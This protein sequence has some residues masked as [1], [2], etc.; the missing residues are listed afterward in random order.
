VISWAGGGRGRRP[1]EEFVMAQLRVVDATWSD[2]M[3]EYDSSF[4]ARE[5]YVIVGQE[6]SGDERGD[7]RYR[8][9]RLVVEDHEVVVTPVDWTS[10][11]RE[12]DSDYTA[13]TGQVLVGRAHDGGAAGEIRYR[14]ATVTVDD[15]PVTHGRRDRSNWQLESASSFTGADDQVLVGRA[16]RGDEHGDTCCT[17]AFLEFSD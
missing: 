7:T 3:R 1:G 2:T 13:E 15:R 14:P 5:G 10:R 17:F 16:H 8:I 12:S 9:A 4:T 6:H 11:H